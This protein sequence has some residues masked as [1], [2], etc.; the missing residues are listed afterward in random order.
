MNDACF[1]AKK[2]LVEAGATAWYGQ[3]TTIIPGSGPCLRCIIDAPFSSA[4]N[5]DT[6]QNGV[7]GTIP[8]IIGTLQALETIKIVTG[9]APVFPGR[10][11]AFDGL[12]C[13][14]RGDKN[15]QKE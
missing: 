12:K 11:L 6:R 7:L 9:I 3:V 5:L 13:R 14:F 8:G 10:L 4:G 15:R 2:P 1:F